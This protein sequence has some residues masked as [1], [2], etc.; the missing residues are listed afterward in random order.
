MILDS[1]VKVKGEAYRIPGGHGIG[2]KGPRGK[3]VGLQGHRG[4][5]GWPNIQDGGS[6]AP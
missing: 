1:E 6:T 3:G 4:S 2:L 5:R